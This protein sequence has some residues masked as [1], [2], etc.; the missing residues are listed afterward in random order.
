MTAKAVAQKEIPDE[1][2]DE[3][4][5]TVDKTTVKAKLRLNTQSEDVSLLYGDEDVRFMSERSLY[6][7]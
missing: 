7:E 4:R 5:Y 1:T 2:K 3:L 6:A